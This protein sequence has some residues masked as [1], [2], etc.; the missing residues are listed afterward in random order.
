MTREEVAIAYATYQSA[1]QRYREQQKNRGFS[2]NPEGNSEG[3][4]GG[5][6]HGE[7]IRLMKSRSF[8]SGCGRKG[9]WHE[10]PECPK[11]Q[12]HVGKGPEKNGTKPSDVGFCNLLPAEVYATRHED[13]G[14]LGIT[15]TACARTVAGSQWLQEYVDKLAKYGTRPELRHECEAYR[16]GAG[17][18]HY[19]SFYVVLAFELGNKIVCVRTS[20]IN[21]DVP[22]L[23]SKTVLSKLGMV[24]DVE[25]GQA[26]FSKVGLK[27]YDLLTTSTGHPAIPI[28][29]ARMQE[30]P[31]S[32][33]AEDLKLVPKREYIVCAVAHGSGLPRGRDLYN[34]FYDKKLDPGVK[35]MLVQE[36]WSRD[37]FL[38][39]WRSSG[40]SSDFWLESRDAWIRIHV[41]PRR[42]LFNPSTWKTVCTIQKEMLVQTSGAVRI[43]DGVCC[44]SGRWIE[45]VV[46]TWTAD[47]TSEPAF[48]F[49]WVGRTWISK[50]QPRS[51]PPDPHFDHGTG[52]MQAASPQPHVQDSAFGRGQ[53]HGSG[54]APHLE[55]G[56]DQS[57]LGG[58]QG[59]GEVEGPNR[60]DEADFEYDFAG[61]P[62]QSNGAGSRLRLEDD[63]GQ[64]PTSGAGH[65]QHPR[66]RAD[67]DWEISGISILR[68]P[69]ELWPM[70]RS[71]DDD[72]SVPELGC[73]GEVFE[74]AFDGEGIMGHDLRQGGERDLG[75]EFEEAHATGHGG[76]EE[77]GGRNRPQGG[78]RDRGA[79]GQV[80][81]PQEQGYGDEPAVSRREDASGAFGSTSAR[82]R[83]DGVLNCD[84]RGGGVHAEDADGGRTCCPEVPRAGFIVEEEFSKAFHCKRDVFATDFGKREHRGHEAPEEETDDGNDIF[85]DIPDYDAEYHDVPDYMSKIPGCD[86]S[87][88]HDA[89]H[90]LK[91]NEDNQDGEQGSG[92]A[93][94]YQCREFTHQD[95]IVF[96]IDSGDFSYATCLEILEGAGHL[97]KKKQGE[98]EHAIEG[99]RELAVFGYYSRGGLH[100]VT[101][102]ITDNTVVGRYLNEFC[103]AHLPEGATWGA[104]SV[105]KGG[106]AKVHR[107]Y[108]NESGSM[109]HFTSFGH[110]SGGQL[111]LA[112]A[113]I[114]ETQAKD[115]EIVWKR[116]RAGDWL[117]GRLHPSRETFVSFDPHTHHSVDPADAPAWQ[118]VAFTPKGTGGAG[119]DVKKFLKNCGFPLPNK[120][121]GRTA[122]TSSTSR[123]CKRQR[124]S[125]TNTVGKLSVLFTT[126]LAATSS[127][128]CEASAPIVQRPH[129]HDGDW[130]LRRDHGGDRA[131]Q[132]GS[133]TTGLGGLPQ[134]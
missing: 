12:G 94:A 37:S 70:G 73:H 22:L 75:S 42:A 66:S 86:A 104:I 20:I 52:A 69:A 114:E 34:F 116:T 81:G 59:G 15:D 40:V 18:I 49:L 63:Q 44:M 131:R 91:G 35:D 27:A 50:S 51:T 61:T 6:K 99:V 90:E 29:P 124:R 98:R 28:V 13:S 96:A 68:N 71:R 2:G 19:S 57:H 133:G 95:E 102:A 108:N 101:R 14:L 17:K 39:W 93:E 65:A 113:K 32:F 77:D 33:H 112:E 4:N 84:P 16:F 118:I 83:L 78:G 72:T 82:G 45:P 110:S 122:T 85:Y 121:S 103:K 132:G 97:F 109:N 56:G 60:A 46:D 88:Y 128:L 31:S 36:K 9:H 92:R 126:L 115:T 21:G 10:D 117:P 123:P 11:N 120:D 55:R 100:G 3:N 105:A 41:T 111:W 8:C 30:D 1:K 24:Y 79:G 76:E 26:D 38:A 87:D 7:K 62:D 54:L 129:S 48:Q 130:W 74:S 67:E 80:G 127:Y 23:L 64:P 53:P 107:D 58:G 43:T 119:K 5:D 106:A 47:I 89:H 25:K 125:I 134:P